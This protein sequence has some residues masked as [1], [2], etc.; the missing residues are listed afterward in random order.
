MSRFVGIN[1]GGS[2][3]DFVL[4]DFDLNIL[5]SSNSYPCNMK[6]EGTQ[7]AIALLESI[8]NKIFSDGKVKP[9]EI[10]GICAGFAGGGR[11][12]DADA[13]RNGFQLLLKEKFGIVPQVIIT[14]DALITLEGA[15]TGKEG[16]VLIAGTGSILYAKDNRDIFH[17]AGGFGRIIGDEGSGYSIGRK[18]LAAAA[19]SLDSRA[20]ENVLTRILKEKYAVDSSESLIRKIYEEGFE[21][22]EFAPFVIG[23]AE[24][25]DEIC[26]KITD[27]ES[28]E[29]VLHL[30]A[31]KNYFGPSFRLC[32]SGGII[33]TENYFAGLVKEKISS[34][35]TNIEIIQPEMSPELGAALLIKKKSGS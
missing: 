7:K 10:T 33:T 18:G 19:K 2:K 20:K 12:A 13:V 17:R 24:S 32:L 28:D 5:Y 25:G 3:T 23:G 21:V 6:K 4:T 16:V 27:E 35:F 14:T 26:V 15:F 9:D 1:A 22:S 30:K 29:L 11:T 8:I 34:R 31:I